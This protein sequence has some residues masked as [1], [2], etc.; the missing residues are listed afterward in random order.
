M[1]KDV[2]AFDV[3]L[4]ED[5]LDLPVDEE[6]RAADV[7]RVERAEVEGEDGDAVRG[8]AALERVHRAAR[9]EEAVDE[10]HWRVLLGEAL[11]KGA[12]PDAVAAREVAQIREGVR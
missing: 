2:D 10:Q 6:G 12:A 5:G 8:E 11:V 1:T 4:R 3:R 9:A 7:A